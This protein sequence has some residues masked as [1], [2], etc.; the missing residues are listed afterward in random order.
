MAATTAAGSSKLLECETGGDGRY[1]AES[2]P[3][4]STM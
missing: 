3:V 1:V 2:A 4:V